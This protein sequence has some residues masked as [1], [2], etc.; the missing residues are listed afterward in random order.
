MSLL[1]LACLL[2][3]LFLDVFSGRINNLTIIKMIKQWIFKRK[4]RLQERKKNIMEIANKTAYDTVNDFYNFH[5][6]I[7][8][9][10]KKNDKK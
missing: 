3:I 1:S 9:R 4:K 5:N 6:K 2:R 7:L 8:D 10:R